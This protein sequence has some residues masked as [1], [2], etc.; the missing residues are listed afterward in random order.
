M[1]DFAKLKV[2]IELSE[3]GN[4]NN[5]TI[6]RTCDSCYVTSSEVMTSV[7]DAMKGL[8]FILPYEEELRE[9][10]EDARPNI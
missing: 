2:S 9:M 10:I 8:G 4:E 1:N 5:I 7:L 3:E 6:D